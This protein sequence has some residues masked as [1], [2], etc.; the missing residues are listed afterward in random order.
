MLQQL[1][2]LAAD[3]TN[4]NMDV[5]TSPSSYNSNMNMAGVEIVEPVLPTIDTFLLI[6]QIKAFDEAK[7]NK[8]VSNQSDMIVDFD[9]YTSNEKFNMV[10]WS[11]DQYLRIHSMEL[12]KIATKPRNEED[13]LTMMPNTNLT[14][15]HIGQSASPN[16]SRKSSFSEINYGTP[17][18]IELPSGKAYI[19]ENQAEEIMTRTS[20]SINIPH[21]MIRSN[22]DFLK[23]NPKCFGAKFTNLP[24][25]FLI[26]ANDG[27]DHNMMQSSKNPK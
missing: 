7:L 23:K 24:E 15:R 1:E 6:C 10:S 18:A 8:F 12:T 20:L 19:E 26:F 5:T 3:Q 9:F 25:Q 2:C 22:H 17:P 21:T 14:A 16:S 13:V 11:R 27:Y 4:P